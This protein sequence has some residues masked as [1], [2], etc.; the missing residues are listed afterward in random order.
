MT[1]EQAQVGTRVSLNSL[2]QTASGVI[3]AD[4]TKTDSVMV[5]WDSTPNRP[6]R[7]LLKNIRP[8]VK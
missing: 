5:A 3:V 1:K 4:H 6:V 8:E 2:V 7:V